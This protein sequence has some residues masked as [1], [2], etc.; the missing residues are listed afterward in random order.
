[1][2][3][4]GI[5]PRKRQYLYQLGQKPLLVDLHH[6][7]QL[8]NSACVDVANGRERFCDCMIL[9]IGTEIHIQMDC[10]ATTSTIL[11]LGDLTHND[12]QIVIKL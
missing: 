4:I 8:L 2:V 5:G 6:S 10:I 11:R 1:M 3:G 9:D 12:T 7:C